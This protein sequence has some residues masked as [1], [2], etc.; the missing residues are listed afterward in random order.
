MTIEKELSDTENYTVKFMLWDGNMKPFIETDVRDIV[1]QK[2]IVGED[3]LE[4]DHNY[5]NSTNKTYTYTYE[6]G[7]ESIDVKFTSDT[8]TESGY[9]YIYILDGNDNQIGKYSGTQLAGITVNIPGNT[10]KIKITSD[11][12]VTKYGFKTESIIVNR[13]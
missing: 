3:V 2:T 6:N 9:D 10:V 5:E 7:W 13:K 4:S 12:S 11:G 8:E 1:T